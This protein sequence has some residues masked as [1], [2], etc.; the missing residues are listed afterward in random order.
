MSLRVRLGANED[1]II[2][3]CGC[4]VHAEIQGDMTGDGQGFA[5]KGL[6]QAGREKSTEDPGEIVK[7][8]EL[9]SMKDSQLT[10]EGVV[11]DE[12]GEAYR[13]F[14]SSGVLHKTLRS[15]WGQRACKYLVSAAPPCPPF[16]LLTQRAP[17][18]CKWTPPSMSKSLFRD[19]GR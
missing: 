12:K 11:R 16:T 5:S 19:N 2:V 15:P 13:E 1:E 17:K 4:L 8:Q 18:A 14:W 10:R 9:R 6:A 3:I 7:C